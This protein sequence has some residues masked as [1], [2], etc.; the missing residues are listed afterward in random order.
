MRKL[1][2]E[3]EIISSWNKCE[4]DPLV[5]IC[6]ASYNHEKYIEDAL[7]GF[8][9]QQTDFPFEILIHDDASTDRTQDIIRE[10]AQKY[11][12]IIKPIYQ[13]ENQY[14]KFI[15]ADPDINFPRAKGKYIAICEGD[16]H[17]VDAMK[18]MIQI[19]FLEKNEDYAVSGHD[20]TI[21]DING[22]LIASSKLPKN[23]QKDFQGKDLILGKVWILTLSMVMRNIPDQMCLERRMVKNGDLFLTSILGHYGKSHF[24]NDIE[25]GVY[26]SHEGGIWSCLS[27]DEKIETHINT[28]FWI[29]R[30]YN[31]I[32]EKQLA[33]Y[34]WKMYL[35]K[36]IL[37][38]DMLT[39]TKEYMIKVLFLRELK[40]FLNRFI[41]KSRS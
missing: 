8:L 29:Y 12:H 25:K 41:Y 17:W 1:R 11:P 40:L 21:V 18:L 32:G 2:T 16:D 35:R 15:H 24:H 34:F 7:E 27:N 10:Y 14:S 37:R 5:S 19:D 31:R 39:L 4:V 22:N 26:R 36:V 20:A 30:Y 6:C 23:Q 38:S 33:K 9:I 13:S 28:Y 3:D